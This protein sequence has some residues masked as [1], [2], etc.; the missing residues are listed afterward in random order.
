MTC[1]SIII[2]VYNEE[3][4]VLRTIEQIQ[5]VLKTEK[6]SGEIIAINDGSTDSSI[7]ILRKIEGID[8]LSHEE[9]RGYGAALKTGIRRAKNENVVII[10]ADGSYPSEH[11]PELLKEADNYDMVVGARIG[12]NA[13]IPLARKPA[14]WVLNKLA[15]YLAKFEIPDL[16]SGL[17]L[18]KK[19]IVMDFFKILPSQ[20]SFTTTITLAMITNDY[21]TKFV[22]I[23]YNNRIGRS[24]IRPFRDTVLFFFL[25]IRIILYFKPL[26]FFGPLSVFFCG[27]SIMKMFYDL[28]SYPI[29]HFAAST[30][31]LAMATFQIV[32]LGLIAD[33][34]VS[35]N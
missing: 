27:L 4:G 31:I 10:D 29:F 35:K 9:N 22:P 26:R 25:T 3:K 5:N 16:N 24:K 2:P 11:I 12:K 15:N 33:L 8:V 17:R 21:N 6:I 34:I 18:M 7:E 28:V 30:I 23:S 13:K 1:V 19:S 20:F 14:K 32:I